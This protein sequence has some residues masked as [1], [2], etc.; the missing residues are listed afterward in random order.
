MFRIYFK[1]KGATRKANMPNRLNC[2]YYQL[3]REFWAAQEGGLVC[4]V[5]PIHED[6]KYWRANMQ[7][8]DSS[9]VR[10]QTYAGAYEDTCYWSQLAYLEMNRF[11]TIITNRVNYPLHDIKDTA[12]YHKSWEHLCAIP[13]IFRAAIDNFDEHFSNICNKCEEN[14]HAGK[15]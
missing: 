13:H 2:E 10:F 8:V 15:T 5:D 11:S 4:L 7:I 12:N 9:S 1:N 3:S 6:K 14:C